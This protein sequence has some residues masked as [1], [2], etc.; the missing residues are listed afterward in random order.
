MGLLRPVV[1]PNA[2]GLAV[3]TGGANGLLLVVSVSTTPSAANMGG[4]LTA[5]HG[6]CTFGHALT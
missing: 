5:T 1:L 2:G 4:L 3:A 6:W